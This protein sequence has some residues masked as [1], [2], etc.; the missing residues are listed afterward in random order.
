ME[1]GLG[2]YSSKW[3]YGQKR[4]WYEVMSKVK[5]NMFELSGLERIL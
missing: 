2:V 3:I 1:H 5:E 4:F